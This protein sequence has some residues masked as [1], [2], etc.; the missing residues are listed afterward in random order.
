MYKECSI[1]IILY[2]FSVIIKHCV[3]KKFNINMGYFCNQLIVGF[4]SGIWLAVICWNDKI[5]INK[6]KQMKPIISKHKT[7]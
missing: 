1:K 5:I 4:L 2:P 3:L 7:G 6:N